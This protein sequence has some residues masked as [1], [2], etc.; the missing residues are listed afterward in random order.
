MRL[1]E[2]AIYYVEDPESGN[3]G[4]LVFHDTDG[5]WKN[6]LEEIIEED[7][8]RHSLSLR[9]ELVLPRRKKCSGEIEKFL[10]KENCTGFFHFEDIS[11]LESI[12]SEGYIASRTLATE[13]G[14]ETGKTEGGISEMNH[15]VS[16]KR[17][18][19][20]RDYARF[21]VQA[22]NPMF[23]HWEGYH[24]GQC[25]AQPCVFKVDW[26]MA[27]VKGVRFAKTNANT[28]GQAYGINDSFL[29]T[30][31][32]YRLQNMWG[33]NTNKRGAEI[34]YPVAAPINFVE[35]IDF[36]S[37][38]EMKMA[39]KL[40]PGWF[41]H[42]KMKTDLR[43]FAAKA[44]YLEDAVVTG[45][46][47]GL[48]IENAKEQK[49]FS[50]GSQINFRYRITNPGCAHKVSVLHEGARTGEKIF[51]GKEMRINLKSA[52]KGCGSYEVRLHLVDGKKQALL[53]KAD[54]E[55]G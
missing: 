3:F 54:F 51:Q 18:R 5:N 33:C 25:I 6:H 4:R 32:I 12:F 21:N 40:T 20:V 36:R 29:K 28:S 48:A 34:L 31:P 43:R 52:I 39:K 2:K 8:D 45:Y 46:G 10:E 16:L 17:G 26:R 47:P 27:T 24:N 14:W 37:K 41:W 19:H 23:Y 44:T 55:V 30:I 1:K 15:L 35:E 42:K 13:K 22:D 38:G 9:N 7:F 53:Y 49:G 50:P 11:K